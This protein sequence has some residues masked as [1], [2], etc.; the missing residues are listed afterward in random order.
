MHQSKIHFPEMRGVTLAEIKSRNESWVAEQILKE[1]MERQIAI[2][3]KN[4]IEYFQSK[5]VK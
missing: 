3:D 2:A 5:E 4:C 1:E